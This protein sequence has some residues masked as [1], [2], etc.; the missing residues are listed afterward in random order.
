MQSLDD[1]HSISLEPVIFPQPGKAGSRRIGT[2]TKIELAYY[3]DEPRYSSRM[4]E[5]PLPFVQPVWRFT[6]TYD[7]GATFEL[8]VQALNPLYLKPQ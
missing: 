2:V 1:Y 6:G 4:P 3:T 8:T 5:A 7:D